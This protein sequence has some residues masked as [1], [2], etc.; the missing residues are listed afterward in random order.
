MSGSR[1]FHTNDNAMACW[2]FCVTGRVQGVYFRASTRDE[3]LRLG[4]SGL[5]RNESD[6][7]VT[8]IACG[9]EDALAA[10]HSWLRQGPAMARVDAVHV[11][12][13]ADRSWLGFVTA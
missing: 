6:G 5:A 13:E 3:A 9:N 10:L 4:L 8:V 7:S 1:E 2:R 12:I 11:E